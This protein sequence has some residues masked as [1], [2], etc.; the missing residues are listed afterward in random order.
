MADSPKTP[1]TA[2]AG[3]T[4]RTFLKQAAAVA[5]GVTIVPR[6]VIAK[7]GMTPPSDLLNIAGVGV[8]G[9]GR[10]NLINLSSQNIVAL[11]DVDWDFANK[12]FERLDTTVQQLKGR[13]DSAKSPAE[14]QRMEDQIANAQRLKDVHLAK[15]TKYTDFREMLEKQKD[16]DAVLVATPDHLHAVIASAAMD[17]G[18]HVYV[19]KPLTWSVAEARH[20]AKKAREKKVATQMGN[21][22]HSSDDARLINEHIAAGT[23]GDVREVHVWTN[24]PLSHWP[25]GI[26]KPETIATENLPWNMTGVMQRL[27]NTMAGDYPVPPQLRW[28]LFLGPSA[29]TTYHP[30]YHPFNWRGWVDWGCGAIGD[31][32]AHLIDHPFWALDLGF[33]TSIETISTPYNK[34]TFPA[35]TMTYYEFAARGNM[36]P[37]RLTWYD[38]ALLPPRPEEM[39]EE[40][41][42]K[43]GGVLY[44]GSKG[45]LIHETYGTNPRL[46]GSLAQT[47]PPPQT[48]PRIA[49][50]HELNW[51]DAAKGKAET[52]SPFEYASRLTETMLLGIVALKAGTKI[53][54]D[55]ENMR[56]TNNA[57][58]N[59]FLKREYREGWALT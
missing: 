39:G 31:M 5:A 28:D 18:K 8:G 53:H 4:R 56:V 45:K 55:G 26:P 37:V 22:G 2:P 23:I 7:S 34:A 57:A 16:I 14:R 46:L 24:R 25:Q 12:G 21:Q 36:P 50:T 51:V 38:G 3:A 48:L 29:P 52:S 58:A 59:D 6:H 27:A 44:I 9:M 1:D 15:A 17:L 49:T 43:T 11:C 33:P 13:L 10:A 35:A 32:G 41:L 42:D 20:L 40:Q 47:P 30:V 19:Q 54:Y